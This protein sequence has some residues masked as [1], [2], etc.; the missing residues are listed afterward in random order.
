[1]RILPILIAITAAPLL[2]QTTPTRTTTAHP[3]TAAHHAA[4]ESGG[5]ARLPELSPKIPALP[6]GTSCAK[7][8]Y[9]ITHHPQITLD[10]ASPMLSP[11]LHDMLDQKSETFSLDFIDTKVGTGPLAEP[12]KWYTVHYTG[13]LLNGTK[14][15]SSVD[16]GE[17]ISFPYGAHRVIEGWDT[18]FDGMRVGGKRRLFVP[19]QLGYGE[20]AHG[21][22]PP[23][24]WLVFDLELIAQS[25]AQPAPP[26]PP[27]PPA[28]PNGA[29]APTPGAAAAPPPVNSTTPS[30]STQPSSTSE[31]KN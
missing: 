28:S 6:A 26:K 25:D 8:L 24:S 16:R 19:Y 27:T 23:R 29:A 13:Y 31:P 21:P 4:T 7:P 12:H 5:C 20:T 1:M 17:P 30:T 14:F 9:T 2:A 10:Y 15:D 3:A 22:I 11:A 18:G